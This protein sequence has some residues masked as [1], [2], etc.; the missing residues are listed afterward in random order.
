MKTIGSK[1]LLVL[2]NHESHT[3]VEFRSFCKEKDIVLLFMPPHSS[4]LLQPLDVGCFAPLKTAFSTQNQALI[5]HHIFYVKKED[6]L[7]SFKTAFQASITKENIQG[8]FRGAGLH[9][10]DPDAVLSR[11]DPIHRSPSPL[12]SHLSWQPQTPC[13]TLEVEKQA[14]LIKKKLEM[15][16]GSSPTPIHEAISQLAKGAQVMAASAALLQSQISHLQRVN[17]DMHIRRKRKRKALQSDIGLSAAEVEAIVNKE[18]VDAQIMD[19][20]RG[21]KRRSPTCSKCKQQGHTSRT[22]R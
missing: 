20:M 11:L 21:P 7:A 6:F 19:E 16:Q 17:E 3:S 14:T 5:R 2:D 12:Y 9:P 13:N 4:H 8:G 1:R 18:Q 15:H 22:C 10:F